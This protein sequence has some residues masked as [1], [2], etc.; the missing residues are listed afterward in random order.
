[1]RLLRTLT[2]ASLGWTA[3][4]AY[5]QYKSANATRMPPKT[6]GRSGMM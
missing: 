5:K 6:M 3:Y 4:K 2:M 1:M